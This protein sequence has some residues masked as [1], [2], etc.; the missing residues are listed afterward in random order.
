MRSL[1]EKCG[2]GDKVHVYSSGTS[3]TTPRRASENAIIALNEIGLDLTKH[4]SQLTT[5]E[6]IEEAD[7]V[8]A[9]TEE[10]KRYVLSILSDARDKVFTLIEY[11][12]GD[13]GDISDPYLMDIDTYRSVRNEI[14]KYLELVLDRIEG[15]FIRR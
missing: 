14:L 3:V 11:A 6:L 10:H 13:K 12:T 7:L 15:E 9:M 1:L 5:R 2:L 4:K 8:L